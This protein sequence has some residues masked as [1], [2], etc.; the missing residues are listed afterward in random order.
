L[1]SEPSAR[2]VAA[3]FLLNGCVVSSFYARL[4]AIKDRL[5]LD[6]GSLGL[7]LVGLTAGLLVAQPLTGALVSRRGSAPVAV[8][9]AA[10]CSLAV[11]GPGLA[12]SLGALIAATLVLGAANGMLD[13]AMNVEGVAVERRSG[14]VILSKLHALFSIG[15]LVGAGSA[16]LVAA[17]GVGVRAHLFVVAGLGLVVVWFLR[18]RLVRSNAPTARPVRPAGGYSD[19]KGSQPGLAGRRGNPAHPLNGQLLFFGA[20][21]FCVLLCEGAVADWSAVHLRETL[22]ESAGA[23]ALGLASFSIAMAAGRFAGDRITQAL[24]E[25]RHI[26]LGALTAAAGLVTAALAPAGGIAIAAFGV[27]GLGLSALFPLTV[28]AASRAG[29]PGPAIAAVSTAGYVGL[30]TGPPAVGLL[31]DAT[32][33]RLALAAILGGLCGVVVLLGYN[34]SQ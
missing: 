1:G 29:D 5:D 25:A 34:H 12:G 27:A 33:L 11:I 31:A 7:A 23:A 24:G 28:R 4:P 18:G 10:L 16:G 8:L 3:L 32:D 15:V 19:T 6:A 17:A 9:G 21:A 26:R 20:I 30:V 14:R 13:V 2:P 22:D